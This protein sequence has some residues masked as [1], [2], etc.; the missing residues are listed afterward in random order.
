MRAF[1]D[2]PARAVHHRGTLLSEIPAPGSDGRKAEGAGAIHKS[3]T[4]EPSPSR[5][6]KPCLP[7]IPQSPDELNQKSYTQIDARRSRRI[8]KE[9]PSVLLDG[10]W[11]KH[12]WARE[13]RNV[14]VLTAIGLDSCQFEGNS[15]RQK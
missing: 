10:P 8:E 4:A 13:V 5:G 2:R 6:R 14:S 7:S 1:R 9:H 12:S 11:L 15:R 3:L